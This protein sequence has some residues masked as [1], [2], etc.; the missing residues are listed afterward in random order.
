MQELLECLELEQIDG[1]I[2][3]LLENLKRLRGLLFAF[4]VLAVEMRLA[5]HAAG[6]NTLTVDAGSMVQ[7]LESLH[8]QMRVLLTPPQTASA[9]C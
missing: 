6:L 1:E 3:L 9:G 8:A 7:S 5:L 2:R 4:A